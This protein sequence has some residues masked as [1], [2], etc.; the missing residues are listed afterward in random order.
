MNK[1]SFLSATREREYFTRAAGRCAKVVAT[2]G[3]VRSA[4]GASIARSG[5]SKARQRRRARAEFRARCEARGARRTVDVTGTVLG[6]RRSRASE[7]ASVAVGQCAETRPR[8]ANVFPVARRAV[9]VA[10]ERRRSRR[11]VEAD[12]CSEAGDDE[13]ASGGNS[14]SRC[15]VR[16]TYR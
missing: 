12:E 3:P 7:R 1:Y 15:G 5:C 6:A 11:R 8:D 16:R 9:G 2:V 13:S 4:P 10:Q 14:A